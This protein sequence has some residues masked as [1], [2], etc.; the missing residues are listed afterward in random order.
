MSYLAISYAGKKLYYKGIAGSFYVFPVQPPDSATG[1]YWA[2]ALP[3]G[4]IIIKGPTSFYHH[5]DPD[6][7]LW[8]TLAA[9]DASI[10][11][12]AWVVSNTC[13]ITTSSTTALHLFN[14][15]VWSSITPALPA[16][17]VGGPVAFS[18]TDIWCLTGGKHI[19]HLETGVWVDRWPAACTAL[20]G[21]SDI[22]PIVNIFAIGTTL[23]FCGNPTAV[24]GRVFKLTGGIGGTWAWLGATFDCVPC[25]ISGPDEANL[26]V[27]GYLKV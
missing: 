13:V 14:G 8:S 25:H 23:Y 11:K 16:P 15:T 5:F 7:C 10:I 19:Y 9:P 3:N 2:V 4:K 6:T 22:G 12:A 26:R 20:A 18:D 17:C 21:G 1:S 27:L 24:T